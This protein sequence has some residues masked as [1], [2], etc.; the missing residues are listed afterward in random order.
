M[1]KSDKSQTSH[2]RT[3]TPREPLA[4]VGIGCRFAGGVDGADTLWALLAAGTDA[5]VPVPPERWDVRRHYSADPEAAGKA[6]VR[7]GGYLHQ[8]L[9]RFDSAFFGILPREADSLDPQQRL[10]LEVAWEAMEDAGLAVERLSGS[11]TGVYIGGF[12]L[13]NMLLQLGDAN[14]ET[15]G[16][17]TA[18][19]VSMTMLSNR[20]S[21]SFDFRGP[22]ISVD[23]ACSSSLVAFHYACQD[24]WQGRTTMALAGGVNIT[25]MPNFPVL[26]SKGG[27]LAPD[28]RSKSF[29]ARADGYG[30]GEGAGIIV[31]KRLSD[32]QAA[33]DRIY[34]LVQGTGVNQDGRTNG[35]TVPNGDAQQAL[36]RQV[37][38][39]AGV[40]PALTVYTEAH[41][42]GT[43][44]GDPIECTALGTTIAR[45]PGR[46][47]DR[48]M[49][50]GSIK[51]NIGHTEAA[52][53]IAGVIKAALC[54]R[55]GAVPPQ[56]NLITPNPK[57]PF[58]ELALKLPRTLEP[59]KPNGGPAHVSVN[60]FGYG[61]TNAHAVLSEAPAPA[62][63][64]VSAGGESDG[65]PFLT[66]VSARDEGALRALATAYADRLAD[67]AMPLAGF[68][69]AVAHRRS[70]HDQRLAIVASDRAELID[71]LRAVG[72]GEL[73][74][75]TVTGRAARG[76]SSAPVFVFTGMG[77]QWWGMGR[78]LLAAEPV[79]RR[80]AE[81][82]DAAFFCH[83]GWSILAELGRS[84]A[85]SRIT[86]NCYAQPA[87]FLI[88]GALAALWRHWGIE[89]AAIVGHSVG[90]V[91]AA[92]VAGA[93]SL[94]D[95]ARVSFHRS[96][97]QQKVAGRG[98]ML[99][100]GLGAEV[101]EDFLDAYAGRVEVAA[102]NGP[103]SCALAGDPDALAEIA[104]F[105]REEGIFNRALTVEVAYHSF[106]MDPLEHDIRQALAGLTPWQPVVP[107]YSTVSGDRVRGAVHDAGYWWRNVRQRVLFTDALAALA[108]DGHSLFLEVGPHPVLAAAIRDGLHAAGAT[109]TILKSL[110]RGHP[111]RAT[112]LDTVGRL[113]STGHAVDWRRFGPPGA[114]RLRTP[115]VDLPRYPWQRQEHWH[116]TAESRRRRVG[117]PG[118][119]LLGLREPTPNP[120]WIAE[121]N[122]GTA[123]W[124]PDHKV[125]GAVVLPG[126]AYVE[127]ALA[128][129]RLL[130]E[131]PDVVVEDIRLHRALVVGS[132][133][134]PRLRLDHDPRSRGFTLHARP[135]GAVA[136][137]TLHATGRL[138]SAR[139]RAV[140][141]VL[142]LHALR[143][144][145]PTEIPA[146]AFYRRM[147]ARGLNYGPAFRAVRRVWSGRDEVLAEL[148][149]GDGIDPAADG[150]GLHPT[151]LDG[152]FQSLIAA[153]DGGS[154]GKDPGG[155]DDVTFVP[156]RLRRVGLLR[157]AG[158]ALWVHGRITQRNE[159]RIEG[160]I[161]LADPE[162]RVVARIEGVRC[163]ALASRGDSDR[164]RLDGWFHEFR[165][166]PA[167]AVEPREEGG[168][169]LIVADAMDAAS[170]DALGAHLSDRNIDVVMADGIDLLGHLDP[171]DTVTFIH[172]PDATRDPAG[173]AACSRLLAVV[174]DLIHLGG[175][176]SPRLVVVTCGAQAVGAIEP[177]DPAQAALW[178]L[179]RV[180]M[181]EHPELRPVLI[182][183]DPARSA[184]SLAAALDLILSGTAEEEIAIRAGMALVRRMVRTG[185]TEPERPE[186]SPVDRPFELDAASRGSLDQI[187][188]RAAARREP[189]PG[190]VEV[191]VR[192]VALSFKD[193]LKL[194]GVLS[195]DVTEGT[196]C[197][198][199][200]GME[201]AGTVLRVGTNVTHLAP[202]DAVALGSA[203][204]LLRSYATVPALEARRLPALPGID[205]DTLAAQ[206]VV[207]PTAWRA[208]V[209]VANLRAGERVLLHSA[210]GGVGL[211][212]IE[213][214]RWKGAE[215]FATAGTEEKRA[216]LRSLGIRQVFD[217]RSL[218]F[219]EEIMAA[220]DGAGIDVA[221][222]F[223]TGE[224][225]EKT[226]DVMAPFGRM[227]EI[228]KR[229]IDE[230]AGLP[231]GR[232]N[233]N[234]TFAS[235][236]L[237][238]LK[239]QRPAEYRRLVEECFTGFVDGR[240]Q[241]VPVTRFKIADLADACRTLMQA[242]QIGKAVVMLDT[243]TVPVLP[244][245][246]AAP[247]FQRDASYL[248]TGGF[249]G[250]GLAVARWMAEQGAGALVLVGRKGAATE[251]ACQAVRELE[252]RG[253][254]VLAA[255][256][257]VA[258]AGALD[259]LLTE[260]RMA[261]PPLKGV[262]HAATVLD[263]GVSSPPWTPTVWRG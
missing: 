172:H 243:G 119:P 199:S 40:D 235:V 140:E 35:I 96:H 66:P 174:Q 88:Q 60:S 54:L 183:L 31:L 45:V 67:P 38:A 153:L 242:R 141:P 30:R 170:I 181:T 195:D 173:E 28:G 200:I 122:D 27:F 90:E 152:A 247:L 228:G 216:L 78:E 94:D 245:T 204:G 56:A 127:A 162:G 58:D 156:V 171:V 179:T 207:Y 155:N 166:E 115:P 12:T 128:A 226:L 209:E 246:A 121:L 237:D 254:R 26:M 206:T 16:P 98:G 154:G 50:V 81:D 184:S 24:L 197:G 214:A 117:E 256:V 22:S 248:I 39:E 41:G 252:A 211:A 168:R 251:D 213:V 164:A 159:R 203:D 91:T 262:L 99:A 43:P 93:L 108:A 4:I 136:D 240:F 225:L 145:C 189:G 146:D 32:A 227:V 186:S 161:V 263:D 210:T 194:L 131:R 55:H 69:D 249:G 23:T 217:S 176:R 82:I 17:N 102:A 80:A 53:G 34:A 215:I 44:V 165:W 182:D 57:I 25:L 133:D 126:A 180:A 193:V 191:R 63:S 13:D 68:H 37:Y 147:D 62:I 120:V 46:P 175:D 49:L 8:P 65:R 51:G 178:G 139:P 86:V 3:E 157:D 74:P 163:Q 52:A 9:D 29:D 138:S 244:S 196:F 144:R 107:L 188:F 104:A 234:L 239:A 223:L 229:D 130:A 231:L 222:N 6:S 201:A 208:L 47:V 106:H 95:A 75:G 253:T 261:W 42:T 202:G 2:H 21:Y 10:L 158:E 192:S 87:N 185:G 64:L 220:T 109:G 212:A 15:T 18:T 48:L 132:H 36:I 187:R 70:R 11:A 129:Q 7:E 111:E 259:R 20:L 83:A 238:R 33:G 112:L 89:P 79:F 92:Y 236:D 257:D 137:W 76:A 77:P 105:L 5:I 1:S 255:A 118:H 113:W 116:E 221:L 177:A 14:L 100:I 134:T 84:E 260:V 143:Q 72:A 198:Q 85:A 114:A 150:Y 123:P 232:F 148:R 258:D 110:Y 73:V 230:N 190:E 149:A 241:P 219:A 61:G 250:F 218:T 142:D 124:L 103:N 205:A 233:E 160:D 151:L 224:S 19:G 71:R 169:W 97:A 167:E 101:A 59:L 125:E 135:A